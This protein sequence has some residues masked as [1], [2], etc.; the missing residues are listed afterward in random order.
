MQTLPLEISVD[1]IQAAQKSEENRKLFQGINVDQAYERYIQ[2]LGLI[3][4]HPGANIAPTRDIDLMW[5][6][7]M[8]HPRQYYEDCQRL[9]GDI[10]DHDGGFGEAPEEKPE[11]ER[12]FAETAKLWEQTYSTPYSSATNCRRNCSSRCTKCRRRV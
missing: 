8:L 7:H 6:V 9:F 4:N 5:H 2:Y 11:L 1:L 12:V 3:Q 10:L